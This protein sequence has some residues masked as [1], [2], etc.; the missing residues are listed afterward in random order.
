MFKNQFKI[1]R[2]FMIFLTYFIPISLMV[3]YGADS[4]RF[5]GPKHQAP[6]TSRAVV[7]FR[8]KCK[9][10]KIEDICNEGFQNLVSIELT[11]HIYYQTPKKG[12]TTIGLTEFSAFTPRTKITIDSRL[13]M[14]DVLFDS[15]VIHELG[16]AILKLN[17][18][19]DKSAIMNSELL[20]FI[21]MKKNYNK[22]IDEM[23]QDFVNNLN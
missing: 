15:T 10:Y 20:D 11:N 13:M 12:I 17:H 21:T 18:C 2:K 16:H 14:D 19:D 23:F 1:S 4:Y 6:E 7:L 5:K 8:S 9:E 22:L 3:A